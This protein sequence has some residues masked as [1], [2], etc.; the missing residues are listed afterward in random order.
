MEAGPCPF[1]QGARSAQE[2][3]ADPVEGVALAA[4]VTE[5]VV[6]DAAA[7][8]VDCRVGQGDGMEV[9]DH[10]GR[11]AEVGEQSVGV[12]AVRVQGHRGHGLEPLEGL[13]L[14]PVADAG[15]AATRD[16]IEEPVT[17]QVHE[18]GDVEG[19]VELVAGQERRLVHAQRVDV[20]DPVGVI[21]EGGV[22]WSV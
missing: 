21:D 11:M 14:E 15:G 20:T 6:L 16:N 13:V 1:I 4:P 18:P 7:D 9:I 3:T 8:V 19:V 10:H 17:G 22:R 5:R 2:Q 12:T